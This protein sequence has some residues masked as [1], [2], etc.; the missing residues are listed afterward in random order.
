MHLDCFGGA[1]LESLLAALVGAGADPRALRRALAALW[2]GARLRVTRAGDGALPLTRVA[3]AV[4][5]GERGWKELR[6]QLGRAQLS[7]FVRTHALEVLAAVARIE[8]RGRLAAHALAELLGLCAALESLAPAR[9]SCTPLPLGH[10]VRHTPGGPEPLPAPATLELLRGIPTVPRELEGETVT[11]LAAAALA[12]FVDEFGVLPALR[13]LAQGLGEGVRAVL[14]E[15]T[16][17]LGRDEVAVLE[18][19]LDDMTPEH[20]A[21]LVERLHDAGA[22]DASLAPL[23]M[24]KGRPGQSLR[25]LTRPADAERLARMVLADSTALGVRVQRVPRLVLRRGAASVATEY[26][27]IR[28]KLSRA[29]D[30]AASVKPEFEACARA[31]R[32]HGVAIGAVTR[33]AQ[34]RAEDELL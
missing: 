2:P 26:G 8:P 6:A 31:A 14:G 4:P 13:P 34:R 9:V 25:V 22:L 21:F 16:P 5:A 28:V 20:L 23:V 3:V 24:K 30:G 10:G 19:H 7:A 29:P 17:E 1:T 18:T 27:P 15:A 33:A 12:A 11:P 32:R